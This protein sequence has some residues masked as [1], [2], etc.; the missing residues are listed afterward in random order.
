MK[1]H[2]LNISLPLEGFMLILIITAEW[3][4]NCLIQLMYLFFRGIEQMFAKGF[5]VLLISVQ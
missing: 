3:L 4:C 2:N 1:K 5:E